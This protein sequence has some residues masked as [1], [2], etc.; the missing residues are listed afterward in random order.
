MYVN[1][2]LENEKEITKNNN[3][4]GITGSQGI[5]CH[6]QNIKKLNFKGPSHGVPP[7]PSEGAML[8]LCYTFKLRDETTKPLKM[9]D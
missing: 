6:S 4:T 7:C 5:S 3:I 1:P 2:Y 9:N 8:R